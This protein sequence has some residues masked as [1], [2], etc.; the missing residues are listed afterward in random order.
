MLNLKANTGLAAM[1]G[2][3][4]TV[5]IKP[6]VGGTFLLKDTVAAL[7]AYERSEQTGRIVIKVR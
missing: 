2:L 5:K 3:I 4:E 1:T 6:V 7:H